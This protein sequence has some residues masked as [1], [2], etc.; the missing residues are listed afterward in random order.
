[1]TDDLNW[2]LSEDR[3][4]RIRAL[5]VDTPAA[6]RIP[7]SIAKELLAEVDRLHLQLADQTARYSNAV[8]SSVLAGHIAEKRQALAERHQAVKD[9]QVFLDRAR[10]AEAECDRLAARVAELEQHQADD[11]TE[12][13][14]TTSQL[15]AVHA[16]AIEWSAHCPPDNQ[17]MHPTDMILANAGRYLISLIEQPGAT[18]TDAAD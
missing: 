6:A 8:P 12:I 15:N 10:A 14:Q 16:T 17:D 13:N 1:M 18:T 11:H 3:R 2:P 4:D 5:L 9:A 7:A